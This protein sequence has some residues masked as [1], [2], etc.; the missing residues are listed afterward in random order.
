MDVSFNAW[1]TPASKSTSTQ[2]N[3]SHQPPISSMQVNHYEAVISKLSD[4]LN[5]LKATISTMASQSNMP[6]GKGKMEQSVPSKLSKAT[7]RKANPEHRFDSRQKVPSQATAKQSRRGSSAPPEIMSNKPPGCKSSMK[8]TAVKVLSPKRH[9]QQ[10]RTGDFPS[11][12]TSTKTA[13]F[14]H[15]KI[16]WGL[17]KQESVPQAPEL[18]MLEEFYQRFKRPEQV[19]EAIKTS[20][21]L[22][23]LEP[24]EVQCFKDARAGRIRF[25]RSVIHLGDNFVRYA[26]GLMNRLG[27]RIWCPNLEEDPSS[28]YNAAHRIAALTTFQELASTSAYTYLNIDP[29]MAMNMN[30]LI[31]GYNHFVHYLMLEKYKKECKQAGRNSKDATHKRLSKNRERLRNERRDFAIVN[32]F[33]MRYQKILAQIGAHSDD[34]EVVGKGFFMIKTLPYRSK[35]AN[36][37]FRR[38]D[39]VM[40]QAA[41]QDTYAK[42]NRRRVRRLPK[43]P[44]EST[45]KAAPKGLPIDFY[46][47]TWYHQLSLSQQSA[48]PNR[49]SLA[50]LPNANESLL[51]KSMRHPDEKLADSSFTRKYWEVSTEP[52]GLVGAES[53]SEESTDEKGLSED[54]AEG[55][56][57]THSTASESDDE[58]LAEGDAGDLYNEEAEEIKIE[59]DHYQSLEDD[60]GQ[61][62]EQMDAA[63]E[64]Y[65]MASIP[66]EE[67][68][69]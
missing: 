16:L 17:L 9:P 48:I 3:P 8:T 10:M 1:A 6:K 53:S 62:D 40:K 41:E 34:E 25:G 59:E 46:D 63:D 61:S 13:L 20:T 57:L 67:F 42:K 24:N 22:T 15:I 54:E 11:S 45:Y 43:V 21:A 52:Y 66:E 60:N 44:V 33:P 5:N 29:K 14:V 49:T 26:Q 47:P 7:T 35:N 30:L 38:L 51:P 23:Y 56:D 37:F 32:K 28:L 64:D 4:E 36:R 68:W 69:Q 2:E 12:F 39:V 50:F 58:Y 18:R 65:N 55:I 19:E 27:L 31:Q